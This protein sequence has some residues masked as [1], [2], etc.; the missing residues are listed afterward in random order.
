[1]SQM[2]L[3]Y[4]GKRDVFE[5]VWSKYRFFVPQNRRPKS[6]GCQSLT[7]SQLI[8]NAQ[9]PE[10]SSSRPD[11]TPNK[12]GRPRKPLCERRDH[13]VKVGF[14]RLN[15]AKLKQLQQREGKSLSELVYEFAVNGYI[16][17]ALPQEVVR[18]IRAL[19]GMA[20]NLNQLAH[21]AHLVCY[22]DVHRQ[23]KELAQRIDRLLQA[24]AERMK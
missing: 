9:T 1:M 5:G 4:A 14:D 8:M 15:Y 16:K 20:N 24:L 6:G 12:G 2:P 18:D 17:E 13:V 19:A 10:T 3:L 22:N 23:N 7:Y 21:E 11:R